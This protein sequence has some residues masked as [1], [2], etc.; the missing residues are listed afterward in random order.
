MLYM[1]F[2]FQT[3]LT[4]IAQPIK[5]IPATADGSAKIQRQLWLQFVEVLLSSTH[6]AT[7]IW[8]PRANKNVLENIYKEFFKRL[9]VKMAKAK[10]TS[11]TAPETIN[12]IGSSVFEGHWSFRVTPKNS[13][14]MKGLDSIAMT[15]MMTS[16]YEEW[17]IT[18]SCSTMMSMCLPGV[19]S[20]ISLTQ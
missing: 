16:K 8:K 9:T 17:H 19:M 2:K 11:P 12:Q 7:W 4:T 13:A 15:M 6:A 18:S 5:K 14:A 3:A 20:E 1:H 10:G